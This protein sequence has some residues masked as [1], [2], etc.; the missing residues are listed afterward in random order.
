MD[1]GAHSSAIPEVDLRQICLL[2]PQS[3]L[4]EGP[5][6]SFQIRVANRD[7]ETPECTV[8]FKFE[9]RDIEFHE[10]FKSNGEPVQ[11]HKW[12]KVRSKEPHSPRHA[13]RYPE[14]PLFLYPTK[15]FL[16]PTE[17]GRAQILKRHGSPT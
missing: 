17:N 8:E 4:K 13:P 11:P 6:P 10:T 9:V 5:A 7:L 2:A 14:L 1:T 16:Y 12:L 15:I 3:I